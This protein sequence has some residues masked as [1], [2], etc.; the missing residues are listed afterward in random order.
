MKKYGGLLEKISYSY[1]IKQGNNESID[2]YK[3]RLIYS[4][5][6]LMGYASLWDESDDGD[7]S[8]THVKSRIKNIYHCYKE[9]YP[10]I[11][12]VLKCSEDEL[13]DE[14]YNLFSK[15][16]VIYHLPHKISRA[17]Y[18]EAGCGTILFKRG[19]AFD[20]IERVSGLGVYSQNKLD[21]NTI[22][23][24]RMFGLNELSLN[25]VWSSIISRAQWTPMNVESKKIE[26]LR[27]NP[28]FSSGYWT[29]A[30]TFSA[31]YSMLRLT[32]EYSKLYYLYKKDHQRIKTSQLMNW[33]TNERSYLFLSNA[34]LSS[35][36]K[37]PPIRYR[38][39]GALVLITLD[40]LLP[41]RELNFLKLYS[42]PVEF[43]MG[44]MDFRRSCTSI[45]FQ[46]IKE[47]LVSQGYC[48]KEE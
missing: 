45:V 34:C 17:M 3:A 13:A 5:C 26:F 9:M 33:Q 14:I 42:W 38:N 19:I 44:K 29:K 35:N 18:S 40:Y 15:T 46:A 24:R 48:F 39:D 47:I 4:I 1:S 23:I 30:P 41:P 2:K 37:L 43:E 21:T 32:N 36:G 27:I 11:D 31:E 25:E 7:V 28:P 22:N 8:V 10:E 16:G 6:G 20:F 12:N